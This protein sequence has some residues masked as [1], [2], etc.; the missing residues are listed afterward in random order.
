MSIICVI[1]RWWFYNNERSRSRLVDV[2]NIH[3]L[4]ILLNH[5]KICEY[6]TYCLCMCFASVCGSLLSFLILDHKVH[7]AIREIKCF[8]LASLFP[9]V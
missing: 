7:G 3:T 1:L 9:Q 8:L 6:F 4:C 5:V 2:N